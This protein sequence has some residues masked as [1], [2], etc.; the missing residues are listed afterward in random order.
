MAT[1]TVKRGDTDPV[2]FRVNVSLVGATIE[3]KTRRR[4]A[5]GTV[6]STV[7][8]PTT[9]LDAAAGTF[10]W[11]RS[12]DDVAVG[13]YDLECQVTNALGQVA[14]FPNTGFDTLKVVSDL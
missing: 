7:V 5:P 3:L 13:V 4:V 2:P 6:V 10:Q 11:D 14:T 12:A 1:T 8:L 9:I